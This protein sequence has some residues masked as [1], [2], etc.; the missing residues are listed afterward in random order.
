M[1]GGG[2]AMVQRV[3]KRAGPHCTLSGPLTLLYED[4]WGKHGCS[5]STDKEAEPDICQGHTAIK[6]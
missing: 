3:E 1:G 6:V 4:L 2:A 5:G